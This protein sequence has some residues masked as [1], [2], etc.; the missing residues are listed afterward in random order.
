MTHSTLS[1]DAANV[2]PFDTMIRLRRAQVTFTKPEGGT[3]TVLHDIDLDVTSGQFVALVGRSGCG[4]TTLL[5][6]IAALVEP[7]SG[8]IEVHGTSPREARPH[9]GFMLARDALLPWRSAQGNVEYGLELRGVDR[10]TRRRVAHDWLSRVHL[11]GSERLWPWQL[12]QGMRQRVALARTWALDP[13][14]LLMDEPFAALDARTRIAVQQEFLELWQ[15]GPQRTV[16][17]VTHDL[18][19]AIALADR[20]V[21]LGEGRILDD[22]EV[23]IER[24]RDL[25]SVAAHPR[26]QELY[27]RFRKSL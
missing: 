27:E 3:R 18:G 9:L 8:K 16:V 1:A 4:K 22:V 7:S 15:S 12:S 14:V 19:E 11:G 10:A 21:L 5:N 17:F 23:G 24:P 13:D 25:E 2:P 26:Y 20:V 6:M